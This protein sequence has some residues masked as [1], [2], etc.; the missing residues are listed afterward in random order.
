MKSTAIVVLGITLFMTGCAMTPNN[1]PIEER[2]AGASA[3]AEPEQTQSAEGVEVYPA[4]G[5]QSAPMT[6]RIEPLQ[7]TPSAPAA[8]AV[9]QSPAVVALLDSADRQSNAGNLDSAA[10]ALERALRIEPRNA[11]L[12]QRLADVRLKQ[13]QPDQAE[14]LALK[15]NTFAVD[16]AATRAA[17]WRIIAKARR[18]RGDEKGAG[19]AESRAAELVP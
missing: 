14:S 8:A 15:S 2:G 18:M 19:E 11:V 7:T 3:P 6:Q 17:N 4:Q 10:A 13:K 5:A 16:D 12:W 1:A 9:P